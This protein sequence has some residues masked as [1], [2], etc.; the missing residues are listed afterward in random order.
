LF[1]ELFRTIQSNAAAAVTGMNTESENFMQKLVLQQLADLAGVQLDVADLQ[2]ARRYF[3]NPKRKELYSTVMT[4]R[5]RNNWQDKFNPTAIYCVAF[6]I[7]A[8]MGVDACSSFD[9]IRR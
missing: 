7:Q 4:T 9:L 3:L 8:P 6:G 1:D 5:L 2:L